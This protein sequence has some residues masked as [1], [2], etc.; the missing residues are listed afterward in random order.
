MN[1][2]TTPGSPRSCSPHASP[3]AW[4]S[5]V[6]SEI[7][8]GQAAHAVGDAAAVGMAAPVHDE[9]LEEL[10]AE[11]AEA[12]W[13]AVV[14][15]EPVGGEVEGAD[16]PDDGGLLAGERGDGGDATLALEVPE[17]LGRPPREEHVGHEM[18]VELGVGPGSPAVRRRAR[19]RSKFGHLETPAPLAGEP[20][21]SPCG[22]RR[23]QRGKK[24]E[25]R[26]NNLHSRASSANMVSTRCP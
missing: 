22:S 21:D 1:V 24:R 11:R 18:T 19:C 9:L 13:L 2:H 23:S 7:C 15:D 5:C 10:V 26:E 17:P 4:G 3:A 14:G 20:T 16:D 25:N 6:P 12:E 8:D